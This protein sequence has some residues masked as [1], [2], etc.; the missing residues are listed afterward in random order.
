[1][2]LLWMEGWDPYGTDEGDALDG[3]WAELANYV[4]LSSDQARTGGYSLQLQGDS[5]NWS[6]AR[7][8]LGATYT[9]VGMGLAWYV[10]NLPTANNYSIPMDFRNSDNATQ[11]E[12]RVQT[13]GA[14]EAFAGGVS[15]G[16]SADGAV[17]ATAWQHIEAK[18]Y[19]HTSAGTVTVRVNEV[20]VLTITG[21]NTQPQSTAGIAQVALRNAYLAGCASTY[22]DDIYTWTPD[23]AG[24]VVNWVG[25]KRVGVLELTADLAAADWTPVGAATGWD[26]MTETPSDDDSSYIQ[27]ADAGDISE[28][29]FADL[30]S[31]LKS[32][33]A[34]QTQV[35]IRK[36][37][38][39]VCT[40]RPSLR[41]SS[42][43]S[44]G[45]DHPVTE[46]WTHYMDVHEADPATGVS[47]TKSGVDNAILRLTRV[48]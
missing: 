42:A 48:A 38:P 45:A 1:M 10:G 25:D 13:T 33:I 32:I 36:N 34:L 27:S 26:A 21:A 31:T 35:K 16:K 30:P 11:V 15:L 41:S 24:G 3:V 28:F 18:V 37:V 43:L 17:T 5:L 19:C 9:T 14:I 7:R 22:V 2:A 29:A 8:I 39:G 46:N 44:D 6:I 23:V 20:P 12:L 40:V 4:N 47:W